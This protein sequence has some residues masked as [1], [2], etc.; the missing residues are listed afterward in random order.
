MMAPAAALEIIQQQMNSM[1]SWA[2]AGLNDISRLQI[3]EL[4]CQP[5]QQSGALL[6]WCEIMRLLRQLSYAIKNH[7]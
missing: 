1:L 4:V 2:T 5:G 7:R 6:Q 3:S